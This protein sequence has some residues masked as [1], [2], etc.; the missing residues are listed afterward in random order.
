M[1]DALDAVA[2]IIAA[3]ALVVALLALVVAVM[4]LR[5]GS[6]VPTVT[7]PLDEDPSM[8]RY[9]IAQAERIEALTTAVTGLQAQATAVG[10]GLQH[11]VQH[12]GLVRYNPF[13]DTGGNQSF[14]LAL[15]DA[16]ADGI[17]LS[18]LHSRTATRVYVKAILNGRSDATLSEEEI[19]ALRDAGLAI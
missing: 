11:A 10:S 15:L 4:G 18:S 9:V 8:E 5:R 3:A 7:V 1:L 12:V 13:G 17:V 16:N 19:A 14:A 6:Q 2:G